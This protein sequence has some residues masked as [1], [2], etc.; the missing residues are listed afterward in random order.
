MVLLAVG[1]VIYS[2]GAVLYA[3]KWPN[4]WPEHFGHHEF[5]HAATVVAAVCHYIAIWFVLLG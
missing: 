1:G 3:T 5:F 2:V 4:P